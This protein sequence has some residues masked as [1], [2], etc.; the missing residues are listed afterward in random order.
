VFFSDLFSKFYLSQVGPIVRKHGGFI[1]K[2]IGDAVMALFPETADDAVR[3]AIAMQHQVSLYNRERQEASYPSIAIGIGLHRGSL[4]L[5]TIG[6]ERRMES[7]VIAD[8]VNLA[9]RLEDLT[10]AY[11]APIL[12]SGSTLLGLEQSSNYQ[13]RFLDRVQVKGKKELVSVFEI[14]ETDPPH[15]RDLKEQTKSLFEQAVIL[16]HSKNFYSAYQAFKEIQK[17]N[18]QDKAVSFYI[19]SCEKIFS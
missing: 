3:A 18:Y 16:Y 12:I 17:I 1:D 19:R 9:S 8:A 4:M 10:K 5:G 11:G 14:F 15:L 2:Y 13:Y 7:T 6:E